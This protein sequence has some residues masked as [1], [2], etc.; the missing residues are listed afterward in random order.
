MTGTLPAGSVAINIIG[1]DGNFQQVINQS[2][3]SINNFQQIIGATKF[4]GFKNP[5]ALF[6]DTV[7]TL[8]ALDHVARRAYSGLKSMVSEFSNFG[9]SIAKMSRRTLARRFRNV[10]RQ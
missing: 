1:K 6:R 3:Q 10:C 2:A 5:A 8:A 7:V 4:P 9:D